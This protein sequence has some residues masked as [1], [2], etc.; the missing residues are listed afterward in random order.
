MNPAAQSRDNAH[1]WVK[2]DTHEHYHFSLG[3]YT[4]Y[5]TDKFV[6]LLT[7]KGKS[8]LE[9]VQKKV[10]NKEYKGEIVEY[11]LNWDRSGSWFAKPESEFYGTARTPGSDPN[12]KGCYNCRDNITITGRTTDGKPITTSCCVFICDTEGQE[13]WCYTLSGS[14]YKLG[15]KTEGMGIL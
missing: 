1:T 2:P 12:L 6:P 3:Q 9:S 5:P 10:Q 11:K 7:D 15:K 4:L 13:N 8:L 14:L